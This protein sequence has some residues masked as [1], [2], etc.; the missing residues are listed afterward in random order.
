MKRLLAILTV[1]IAVMPLVL[2]AQS[3]TTNGPKLDLDETALTYILDDNDDFLRIFSMKRGFFYEDIVISKYNKL[4]HVVTEQVV[5]EDFEGRFVFLTN[6]NTTVNLV[7]CITNKKNHT[8]EF[9]KA[10]FPVDVKV[11]KKLV[12]TTMCYFPVE[13][14]KEKYQTFGAFNADRSKFAIVS[15]PYPDRDQSGKPVYVA[16]FDDAGELLF[17]ESKVIESYPYF[18]M[19]NI[20]V[21]MDGTVYVTKSA[22]EFDNSSFMHILTCSEHGIFNYSETFEKDEHFTCKQMVKPNGDLCVIG[23]KC[24]E[25]NP[26]CKLMT[27]T[28][29]PDGNVDFV[30]QDIALSDDFEGRKYDDGKLAED[31]KTLNP[32]LFDMIQLSNGD[33]LLVGEMR[34]R[35]QIGSFTRTTSN[36]VTWEYPVFGFL[37]H[38]M[39]YVKVGIDGSL[40]EMN[41]YQRATATSEEGG[42]WLDSNPVYAFEWDG[43][44]YLVYNDHRG[45]YKGNGSVHC[46]FYNRPDQCSVVL[47]KIEG[48]GELSSTIIYDAK[49]KFKDPQM[50]SQQRNHEYF[51][52]P[53]HQ[54]DEG[55]YY[56]LKHDG[57]YRLEKITIE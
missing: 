34:K 18:H 44:A 47:S 42:R 52:K 56:V 33:F 49:S 7:R 11:P 24:K 5:D 14:T 53:L 15:M 48:N 23:I 9:Q 22:S 29:T 16:V 1:A 38:N 40:R 46:L 37:S 21:A 2:K 25:G 30:D 51:L 35:M 39:Y 36:G 10:S 43:D 57:E 19:D 17:G 6:N 31:K 3:T 26:E 55:I 27:Y 8:L 45:N 12:F 4:T 28:A 54:T 20:N 41:V 32:H 13:K 50:I